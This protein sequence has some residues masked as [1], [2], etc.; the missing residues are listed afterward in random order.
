MA[1]QDDRISVLLYVPDMKVALIL[2]FLVAAVSAQYGDIHS[3]HDDFEQESGLG[4]TVFWYDMEIQPSQDV[5]KVQGASDPVK[6]SA[7]S[8][9]V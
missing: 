2:L 8:F 5:N 7:P 9:A 6:V 3:P 1:E 4:D